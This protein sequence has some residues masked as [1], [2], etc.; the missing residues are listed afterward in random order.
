MRNNLEQLR[1]ALE[2]RKA[3]QRLIAKL[4]AEG[5]G[6]DASEL[7]AAREKLAGRESSLEK[8]RGLVRRDLEEARKARDE[9]ERRLEEAR[10]TRTVNFETAEEHRL[11]ATIRRGQSLVSNL[12][13]ALA[14]ESPEEV[15][16]ILAAIQEEASRT[17][18]VFSM[19]SARFGDW[20]GPSVP[21]RIMMLFKEVRKPG[22]KKPILFSTLFMTVLAIVVFGGIAISM[23]RADPSATNPIGMGEAV[24]PV[25]IDAARDATSIEVTLEYDETILTAREVRKGLLSTLGKIAFDVS[26]PGTISFVVSDN[27]GIVGSGDLVLILFK[28]NVIADDMDIATSQTQRVLQ[29]MVI[30][31]REVERH[32]KRSQGV[33]QSRRINR[34]IPQAA[35]NGL[36]E[37]QRTHLA[38]QPGRNQ[39]EVGLLGLDALFVEKLLE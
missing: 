37:R 22:S 18:G 27:A 9:A 7:A 39:E 20:P 14:A 12:E 34:A 36:A 21:E 31:G 26:M 4:E 10:D 32:R 17:P 5:E 25:M 2:S 13:Q 6:A 16:D 23:L 19:D 33:Q 29:K 15:R 11:N 35:G 24:V 30:V 38:L 3:S 1:I 8:T 28:V